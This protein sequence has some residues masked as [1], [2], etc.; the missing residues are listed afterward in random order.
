MQKQ[1]NW[2]TASFHLLLLKPSLLRGAPFP[3]SPSYARYLY[4]KK[5]LLRQRRIRPGI[6]SDCRVCEPAPSSSSS[7]SSFYFPPCTC[8]KFSRMRPGWIMHRG[9]HTGGLRNRLWNSFAFAGRRHSWAALCLTGF[10]LSPVASWGFALLSRLL[11][12]L[13]KSLLKKKKM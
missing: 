8:Q 3:T 12:T 7:S 4:K 2:D 1:A 6:F 10:M 9:W 11:Q 13:G 5:K